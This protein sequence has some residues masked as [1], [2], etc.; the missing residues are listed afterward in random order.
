MNW[1]NYLGRAMF[2]VGLIGFGLSMCIKLY[3]L[4]NGEDNSKKE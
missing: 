4:I 1:A 3:D 2:L